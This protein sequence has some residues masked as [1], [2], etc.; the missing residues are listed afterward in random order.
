MK[1]FGLLRLLLTRILSTS[2]E[3]ARALLKP[4]QG[5][6]DLRNAAAHRTEQTLTDVFSEMGANS[7]FATTRAAW[8]WLV[9]EV[10]TSLTR[11]AETIRRPA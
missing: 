4:L 10:A 5:T 6:A 2:E 1:Q 11:L 8:T 9:D 7:P 3:E